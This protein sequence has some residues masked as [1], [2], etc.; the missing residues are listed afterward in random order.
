MLNSRQLTFCAPGYMGKGCNYEND[1]YHGENA[2]EL[3][4]C[5]DGA[6]GMLQDLEQ[7]SLLVLL[8]L[9]CVIDAMCV[10]EV[11]HL[12]SIVILVLYRIG[13]MP[14]VTPS[15]YPIAVIRVHHHHSSSRV[16]VVI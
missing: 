14:F 7:V 12:N 5:L 16:D 11:D 3:A 8:S 6:V 4:E 1:F 15:S 13:K 9:V 10:L 2:E